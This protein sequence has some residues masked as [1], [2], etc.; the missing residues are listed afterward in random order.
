MSTIG[1]MTAAGLNLAG[2][3]AGAARPDAASDHAKSLTA[4]HKAQLDRDAALAQDVAD[5]EFSADRDADGRQL[6]RRQSPANTPPVESAA[7]DVAPHQAPSGPP[8]HAVDPFGD[9]GNSLDVDA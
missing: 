5:T 8:R 7:E 3:V 2:S 9:R 6:Y 4:D 1:G